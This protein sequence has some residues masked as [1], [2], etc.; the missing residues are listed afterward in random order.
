M[1]KEFNI[2]DKVHLVLQYHN[3]E[4]YTFQMVSQMPS[5]KYEA[6][7]K[8]KRGSGASKGKIAQK[9]DLPVIKYT[10]EFVDF[11]DGDKDFSYSVEMFKEFYEL[12][13]IDPVT[14][15][16]LETKTTDTTKEVSTDADIS[17]KSIN[18]TESFTLNNNITIKF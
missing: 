10:L 5:P 17:T 18:D 4:D 8:K 15:T 1:I 9:F 12:N 13:R 14:L 6:I 2:G 11:P 3:S 7:I 16:F